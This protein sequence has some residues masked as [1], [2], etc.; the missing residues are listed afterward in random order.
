MVYTLPRA[1]KEEKKNEEGVGHSG[2][3]KEKLREL[4]F[5]FLLG[6]DRE[7]VRKMGHYLFSLFVLK[8]KGASVIPG[9]KEK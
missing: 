8:R 4:A 5:F 3:K 2:E 6:F 9:G 1:I 7:N